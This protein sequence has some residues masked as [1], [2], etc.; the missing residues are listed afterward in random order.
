MGL[1]ER[2]AI[3]MG[4]VREHLRPAGRA[5]LTDTVTKALSTTSSPA[6]LAASQCRGVHAHIGRRLRCTHATNPGGR[7]TVLNG[8]Q[9]DPTA[10]VASHGST[11]SRGDLPAG[12]GNAM[13]CCP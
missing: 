8:S 2:C 9:G 11:E 1:V 12:A 10:P 4:P 7:A 3:P 13:G 5:Q 6:P